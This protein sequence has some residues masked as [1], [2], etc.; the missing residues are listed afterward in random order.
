[1]EVGIDG[2]TIKQKQQT[3]KIQ[4]EGIQMFTVKFNFVVYKILY[5]II[6]KHK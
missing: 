5:E 3:V 6:N 2:N 1:M 4:A